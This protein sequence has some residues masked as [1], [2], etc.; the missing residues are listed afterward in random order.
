MV[1]TRNVAL[2]AIGIAAALVI[3]LILEAT[4]AHR[5]GGYAALPLTTA[6]VI[7][8]LATHRGGWLG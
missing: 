7:F 2:V 4:A 8:G 1:R 5:I 6:V 3:A